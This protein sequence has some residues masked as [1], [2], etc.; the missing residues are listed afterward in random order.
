MIVVDGK[1]LQSRQPADRGQ[2]ADQMVV[3]QGDLDDVALCRIACDAIPSAF[4][5]RATVPVD[6]VSPGRAIG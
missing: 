1:I 5:P 3:R 2:A 4:R 6:V